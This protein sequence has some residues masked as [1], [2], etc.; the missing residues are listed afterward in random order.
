[1]IM[2][3]VRSLWACLAVLHRCCASKAAGG[4]SEAT[5]GVLLWVGPV[6]TCLFG[7]ARLAVRAQS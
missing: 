5:D 7:I 6:Q 4:C 2:G 1:M 3:I